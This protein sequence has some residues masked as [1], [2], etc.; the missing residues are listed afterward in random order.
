MRSSW[1]VRATVVVTAS[2]MLAF[3]IWAR[4][5][6]VGFADFASWPHH[7]HFLHDAGVFQIGIGLTMLAALF[8]RDTIA[9][10]LAGFVVTNTFHAVNHVLDLHRGG[11]AADPWLLLALSAVGAVGFV[12]RV[13]QLGRR[14]RMQETTGGG[15]Q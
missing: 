3:G 7:V 13:R 6:P 2:S 9:V 14:G 15:R 4:W 8:W 1:V 10:V 11:N 5:D 12:L